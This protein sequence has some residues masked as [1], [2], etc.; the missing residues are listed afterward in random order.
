MICLSSILSEEKDIPIDKIP[1]FYHATDKANLGKIL[2]QGIKATREGV[3]LADKPEYAVRFLMIRGIKDIIVF[4]IDAKKLD[5]K[6]LFESYD[7]SRSF[8]KCRAYIY[9]EDIKPTVILYD[10]TLQ[11]NLK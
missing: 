11:Y 5:K 7:H 1:Y 10:K 3:Y 6:K 2:M 8:F 9:E 4:K